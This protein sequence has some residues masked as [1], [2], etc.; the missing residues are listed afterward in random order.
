M[1]KITFCSTSEVRADFMIFSTVKKVRGLTRGDVIAALDVGSSKICCLI[2]R[3]QDDGA[4]HIIGVGQ[5]LSKG[6]RAGAIVDMASAERA[7]GTTVHLAEQMAGETIREVL[8]NVS[9][10]HPASHITT[11]E[12]SIGGRQVTYDDMRRAVVQA[13]FFQAPADQEKIHN[14]VLGY[15]LDDSGVTHDPR[16]MSGDKLEVQLHG[17]TVGASV[18][19]NLATCVARCHLDINRFVASPYAAGLAALNQDEMEF[20]S[21]LIDMGAG[22]TTISVFLEG[23]CVHIDGLPIGGG[24][25]TNDI[26]RGLTTS[27]AHAERLK[28]IYGSA[29]ANAADDRELIDVPLVGEDE[30]SQ[31]NHV[32][33]SLLVGIIEPRLEEILELVRSRLEAGGLG[34]A[35]GLRV[36]LTGGASQMKG[37]REL[38]QL[39]LDKRVR[40]GNAGRISGLGETFTGPAFATVAGLLAFAGE[41][42]EELWP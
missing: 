26:A 8:V 19:R 4:L 7:I 17:V 38:A 2:A 9:G 3:V 40:L 35:A 29:I 11:G 31:G 10:G 20:G 16:G 12:I 24:H 14:I 6:I 5:Q 21:V 22:T 18:V 36:V 30:Q 41:G 32:P 1:L 23:K 33:K 13:R 42:R 15:T 28:A 37:M 25:V 34:R 39:I 27:V